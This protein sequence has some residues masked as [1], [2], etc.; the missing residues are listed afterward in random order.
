[1]KEFFNKYESRIMHQEPPINHGNVFLDQEKFILKKAM[2]NCKVLYK[3]TSLG[4]C[5]ITIDS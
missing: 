4:H 2:K 5:Y 3:G 1:M